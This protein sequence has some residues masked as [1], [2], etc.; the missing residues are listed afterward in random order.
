MKYLFIHIEAGPSI[1]S[2]W[3]KNG[4]VHIFLLGLGW[5][6]DVENNSARYTKIQPYSTENILP[7]IRQL[8]LLYQTILQ[9]IWPDIRPNTNFYLLNLSILFVFSK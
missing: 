5:I 6:P 4:Y 8:K 2:N 9:I 3:M 7:D 1:Q